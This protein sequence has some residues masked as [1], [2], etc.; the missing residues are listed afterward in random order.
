MEAAQPYDKDEL[1]NAS[2]GGQHSLP[3]EGLRGCQPCPGPPIP[4]ATADPQGRGDAQR[5]A[6]QKRVQTLKDEGGVGVG[7]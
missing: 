3:H 2:V 5:I 4:G 6:P 1:S 7:E